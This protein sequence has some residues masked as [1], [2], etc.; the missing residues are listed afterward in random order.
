M[1]YNLYFEL[2]NIS[3]H[4]QELLTFTPD[5]ALARVDLPCATGPIVLMFW[6]AYLEMISSVR[7]VI[8][9][10]LFTTEICVAPI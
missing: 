6:V 5:T 8:A 4:F 3:A 9:S 2:D 1:S 7:G 10:I